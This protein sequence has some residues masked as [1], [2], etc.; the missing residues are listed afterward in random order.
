MHEHTVNGDGSYARGDNQLCTLIAE[1][2]WGNP[3]M[4]KSGTNIFTVSSYSSMHQRVWINLVLSKPS[5]SPWSLPLPVV[6]MTWKISQNLPRRLRCSYINFLNL[7]QLIFSLIINMLNCSWLDNLV[8]MCWKFHFVY[9]YIV[10]L[11]VLAWN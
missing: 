9:A 7:D 8:T 11:P 1:S 2:S 4:T 10:S 6:L 3:T 5:F